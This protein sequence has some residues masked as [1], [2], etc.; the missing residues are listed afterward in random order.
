MP[1]GHFWALLSSVPKTFVP[2][3]VVLLPGEVG[4]GRVRCRVQEEM[5]EEKGEGKSSRKR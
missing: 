2:K 3:L 1:V 5:A 4:V